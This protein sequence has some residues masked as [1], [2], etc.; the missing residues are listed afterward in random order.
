MLPKNN[1]KKS[2]L[3]FTCQ[4]KDICQKAELQELPLRRLLQN[5]YN[6]RAN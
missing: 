1:F 3:P 4:V 6:Q 2:N 5:N